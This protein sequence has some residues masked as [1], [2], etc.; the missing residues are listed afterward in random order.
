MDRYGETLS[1]SVL[2]RWWAQ[3]R[4][5]G[6]V[7]ESVPKTDFRW[8]GERTATAVEETRKKAPNLYSTFQ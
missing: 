8:D 6:R 1:E 2:E 3:S 7:H 5:Q 4:R